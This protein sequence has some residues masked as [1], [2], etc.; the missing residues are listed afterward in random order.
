MELRFLIDECAGYSVA[1]YLVSQG[2]DVLAV[3]DFMAQASDT[4]VLH[5]AFTEKRILVTTDKGFGVRVFRNSAAHAGVLLLRPPDS[6]ADSTVRMAAQVML[7]YADH[8]ANNYVV[9]SEGKVRIGS[10][11]IRD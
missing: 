2:H 5:V 4:Q 7:L 11:S 6:T 10:P 9:S 3:G 8:L 1:E